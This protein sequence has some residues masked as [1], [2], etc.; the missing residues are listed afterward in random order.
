[1]L[2]HHIS[3]RQL[4]KKLNVTPQAVSSLLTG[5][6]AATLKTISAITEALGVPTNYF[7]NSPA[8]IGSPGNNNSVGNSE[9]AKDLEIIN[10]K[11]EM[12]QKMLENLDL[13]LKLL[14]KK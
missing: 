7:F 1:M 6:N 11:F 13:R 14:E 3:Q 8:M 5:K 12:I 4:A 2:T 10:A 9:T